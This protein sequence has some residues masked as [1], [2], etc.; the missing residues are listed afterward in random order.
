M[1]EKYI[2]IVLNGNGKFLFTT[3]EEEANR[4][5]RKEFEARTLSVPSTVIKMPS[6]EQMQS[7]KDRTLTDWTFRKIKSY[8][9]DKFYIEGKA[10]VCV[11]KCLEDKLL[12]GGQEAL[13]LQQSLPIGDYFNVSTRINK[14][15]TGDR[16]VTVICKE[17]GEKLVKH[18]E[19][20]FELIKIPT[21]EI[22]AQQQ[23]RA[24]GGRKQ[25]LKEWIGTDVA[26]YWASKKLMP[27]HVSYQ[28][29]QT[30]AKLTSPEAF[31]YIQRLVSYGN[32]FI[33]RY[34]EWT[35]NYGG[36]ETKA[37]KFYI[38]SI[39]IDHK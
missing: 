26:D 3:S 31:E 25:G 19:D 33:F 9:K 16:A 34:R 37:G 28:Y 6:Q 20:C 1:A 5:E 36:K 17:L 21:A 14:N 15:K 39:R 18:S 13:M 27:V 10:A 38:D 24:V 7:T 2:K 11:E 23:V 32:N 35:E 29:I 4:A 30:K 8:L 12:V 22:L